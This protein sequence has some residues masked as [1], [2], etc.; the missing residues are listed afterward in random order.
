LNHS[1]FPTSKSGRCLIAYFA[2]LVSSQLPDR[3]SGCKIIFLPELLNYA[4]TTG[5][6]AEKVYGFLSKKMKKLCASAMMV[7]FL[8]VC[9]GQADFRSGYVITHA[10]DT[11]KGLLDYRLGSSAYRLCTFK[12]SKNESEIAYNGG[13]L[14]GY[15]FV[16]DKY[17][18]ARKV[19]DNGETKTAFVEVIVRGLVSLYR[20]EQ[21]FFAEKDNLGLQ[22]LDNHA[23]ELMIGFRSSLTAYWNCGAKR[24]TRSSEPT[25]CRAS[26]PSR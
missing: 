14:T 19:E 8:T 13:D 16:N 5:S 2:S 24:R 11:I 3:I 17:F 4:I 20:F 7:C 25:C 22:P 18:E 10:H 26:P 23:K 21:T 6:S 15:G 1:N 9:Y 12:R